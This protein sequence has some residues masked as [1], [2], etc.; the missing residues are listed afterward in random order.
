MR[1]V[2]ERDL[3]LLCRWR[4]DAEVRPFMDDCREVTPQVMSIWLNRQRTGESA[5]AYICYAGQKPIGYTELKNIDWK[6]GCCEGGMFLFGKEYMGTGLASAIALCR[7]VIMGTLGLTTMM[8]RVR[9]GNLRGIKF[10]QKYGGFRK[11]GDA[12]FL[13]FLHENA[14]RRAG[15]RVL[16]QKI[17][18][19]ADY[20]R[21]FKD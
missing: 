16:A 7:E 5:L 19:E 21:F 12:D 13:L 14:P 6:A 18:K 3:P 2:E 10:C 9:S 4:N 1:L 17:G 15:L 11:G 20:A 8:S